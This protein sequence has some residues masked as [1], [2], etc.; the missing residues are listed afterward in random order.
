MSSVFLTPS[1]MGAVTLL[2]KLDKSQDQTQ[3]A[4]ATGKRINTAADNPAIWAVS[5]QLTTEQSR[6]S[7]LSDT[8]SLGKATVSVGRIAAE[9]A[10]ALLTD[11]KEEIIAASAS[12][13]NTTSIQSSIEDLGAQIEAVVAGAS[14]NGVNLLQNSGSGSSSMFEILSSISTDS[15]GNVTTSAINV[16]KQD[17][18]SDAATFGATAETATDYFSAAS[19]TVA[20]SG[21]QDID[22]N[23]ATV[24]YGA[25][26]RVTLEGAG[27]HELGATAV[28]FEYV[29]RLGDTNADVAAA[30][31]SQ[32]DD[33]IEANDLGASLSTSY[34]ASNGR[35]TINNLDAD[36]ADMIDV[37][38]EAATG[39][40]AGGALADL[41]E[42]DVTTEQGQADALA[43]IETMIQTAT[44]AAASLGTAESRIDVQAEFLLE[45]NAAVQAGIS[46]LVDADMNAESARLA[47]QQ[48]QRELAL[49][50]LSIAN[51]QRK[52]VL[53][54]F[55]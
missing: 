55:Q 15:S 9:K 20:A 10:V 40:A 17:L 50:V 38:L 7:A 52:S 24:A 45:A 27:S 23:A 1:A 43:A 32:I 54:L 3:T 51:D 2:S 22:I 39:G 18:Q 29:A 48:A 37:T 21:S 13:A 42:I 5:Q 25:S 19:A 44:A 14:F 47:A 11:I 36:A 4:I 6:Y 30:L 8:L 31:Q 33:Y 35:V 46:A 28:D 12:G 53:S 49:H 26:Y 34:D 16:A 41:G